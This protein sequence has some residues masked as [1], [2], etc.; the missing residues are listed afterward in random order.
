[1]INIA[2]QMDNILIRSNALKQTIHRHRENIRLLLDFATGYK[3]RQPTRLFNRSS[4]NARNTRLVATLKNLHCQIREL[5]KEYN[6][7]NKIMIKNT[8]KSK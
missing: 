2:D 6:L 1:M 8:E 4:D 7:L 5:Q 3:K